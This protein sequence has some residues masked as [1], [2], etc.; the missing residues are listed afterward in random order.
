MAALAANRAGR[1]KADK[2][3]V[4]QRLR[5]ALVKNGRAE[6]QRGVS[7]PAPI[8]P[9]WPSSC[10]SFPPPLASTRDMAPGRCFRGSRA[11]PGHCGSDRSCCR[12]RQS[13]RHCC[14]IPGGACGR[15]RFCTDDYRARR[16][17][18]NARFWRWRIRQGR[19]DC[20]TADGAHCRCNECDQKQAAKIRFATPLIPFRIE[21]ARQPH[22]WLQHASFI[23]LSG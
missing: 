22:H 17:W 12:R 7:K 23:T 20:G 4:R 8:E 10:S 1:S 5:S 9:G 13:S 18:Q 3:H 11:G 6:R 14:L 16:Y 15:R 21:A 2:R 19:N